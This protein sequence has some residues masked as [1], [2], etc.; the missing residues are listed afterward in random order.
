MMA[1]GF[2]GVCPGQADKWPVRGMAAGRLLD[3]Q[4]PG[5]H[6]T[7]EAFL[8][9]LDVETHSLSQGCVL[10]S[11][12]K[13]QL[14]VGVELPGCTVHFA[15]HGFLGDSEEVWVVAALNPEVPECGFDIREEIEDE[16]RH[17]DL[18]QPAAAWLHRPA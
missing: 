2:L 14:P 3:L 15:A 12:S 18:P 5:V 7:A 16:T 8:G 6:R 17:P 1:G 13:F 10:I 4:P 9:L 11:G